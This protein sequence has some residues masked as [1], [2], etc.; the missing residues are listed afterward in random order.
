MAEPMLPKEEYASLHNEVQAC[1]GELAAL[2]RLCVFGVA[3]VFAWVAINAEAL[4]G[5]AGLVWLV[6]FLIAVYGSL[7]AL[8]IRRHISVLGGCLRE[9]EAQSGGGDQG[10]R[11]F[12]RR[13]GTRKWAA[14]AAWLVFVAMTVAGSTLGFLQFRAECPG[15][16][17]NACAQN[18]G[19]DNSQEQDQEQ[20]SM[21]LG[22]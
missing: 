14:A 4:V 12:G 3:G 19:A 8:A 2:E 7:K 1:M 18:D 13:W 22:T 20:E 11:H 6:P 10:P 5:F 9:L 15:P 17:L 21:K 16:L